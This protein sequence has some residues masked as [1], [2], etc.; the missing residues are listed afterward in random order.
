MSTASDAMRHKLR[1]SGEVREHQLLD[2]EVRE[3]WDRTAL[4]RTLALMLLRHRTKH[5]LS[6]SALAADLGMK[7]PAIARLER[8][9]RPVTVDTLL[10]LLDALDVS[11]SLTFV[12]SQTP[13]EQGALDEDQVTEQI[14]LP[15]GGHLEIVAG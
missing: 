13:G 9:D 10:R 14:R 2:P 1:S 5:G 11:F 3:E 15:H 6:Q 4:A 8:G 7:Q 12:P